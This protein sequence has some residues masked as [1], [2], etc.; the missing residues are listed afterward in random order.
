MVGTVSGNN[1]QLKEGPKSFNSYPSSL[2]LQTKQMAR[3]ND[4]SMFRLSYFKWVWEPLV[5]ND[6]SVASKADDTA[7]NTAIW[8]VGGMGKGMEAARETLRR[9]LH[10]WWYS[11]LW[12]ESQIFVRTSHRSSDEKNY[13]ADKEGVDECLSRAKG[14]TWWDWADGSRLFFWK[15]PECWRE[16]ARDGAKAFHVE[17]PKRRPMA[18]VVPVEDKWMNRKHDEKIQ[19]LIERR[20]IRPLKPGEKIHVAIPNFPVKKTEEDTRAV[21]SHTETGVNPSI[22]VP[23]MFLPSPSSM[24]RRLPPGGWI[25]DIDSGEMFNNFMMHPSERML[26]G[27]IISKE[28]QMKLKCPEIMWW[29]RLLFGWRPAPLFASRMFMRAIELAERSPDDS[30]SAF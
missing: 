17:W 3:T 29:D 18:R 30:A 25:G 14:S 13:T 1:G 6:V 23:R 16:E 12:K 19:K 22:Y 11:G 28:L 15:W 2:V 21:W 24:H 20:Y 27:V 26:S 10:R 9:T 4:T 5:T 7:V 8:A